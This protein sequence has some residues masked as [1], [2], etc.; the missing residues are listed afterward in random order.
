MPNNVA[1]PALEDL[2]RSLGRFPRHVLPEGVIREIIS[3][4]PAANSV[5]LE[6]LESAIKNVQG[7][8]AAV[9]SEAFF[10][11]VLL[12]SHAD[13]SMLPTLR[14]LFELENKDLDRIIGDL[15]HEF[16]P[17]LVR[18][19]TTKDNLGTVRNWIDSLVTSPEVEEYSRWALVNVLRLWVLDG[20]ISRTDAI[21]QLKAWLTLWSDL[22]EDPVSGA[23]VCEL[24]DLHASEEK[25][26]VMD[27][28]DRGQIEEGL[29]DRK[30]CLVSLESK[31]GDDLNPV[32]KIDDLI[33]Y[34]Y[35][36]Q[37]FKSTNLSLDP[38]YGE[39]KSIEKPKWRDNKA[40]K[41]SDIQHWLKAL[42]Q[43]NNRNYP[44]EA[45][46]N[47]SLHASHVADRLADEV[48]WGLQQCGTSDARSSNG[49][50]IAASILAAER[51]SADRDIFLEI[52]DLPPD[53]RRDL[54]GDAI[55]SSVVY[56]LSHRLLGNC[57]EIDQRIDDPNR[58]EMNRAAMAIF[59]P[60]SVDHGYLTRKA[61]IATLL[62]RLERATT[63]T[64]GLANA[65]F[66]S[67]CLLSV[68]GDHPAIIAAREQGVC[69]HVLSDSD[70]RRCIKAPTEA[71]KVLWELTRPFR[72]P[73]EAIE[74]SVM[75]DSDVINPH[76]KSQGSHMPPA[77]TIVKSADDRIPRN[78]SCP[79][80]SGKKYKKCCWKS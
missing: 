40:L 34:F 71:H 67:L 62:S 80:G 51:R 17:A 21:A 56:A 38:E 6:R 43:S 7:G 5:L 63:E 48:R 13:I 20:L 37:S 72:I 10:C 4:G 22:T 76:T 24:L 78:S 11:Y 26:F 64:P 41:E 18:R 61:C 35:G 15:K 49:P 60:L 66:D 23:C 58:D 29:V 79:C 50:F 25:S 12:L 74:S 65:I 42:R 31:M 45:V 75:F 59:Y 55:E 1:Q 9:P 57:K 19:L 8:I 33:Q 27:C 36:W 14:R 28:F 73:T 53:D 39:L 54:F 2:V 68:P 52:L 16:T 44:Y 70:V 69:N 30:S 32:E 46:R 77:S 3:R 47:L